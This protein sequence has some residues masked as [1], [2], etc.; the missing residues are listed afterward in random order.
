MV[1]HL[2]CSLVNAHMPRLYGYGLGLVVHPDLAAY[3]CA[4]T[5]DAGSQGQRMGGCGGKPRCSLERQWACAW[6]P[7]Q[8]EEALAAQ[9]VDNPAG[10]NE[11]IV[12]KGHWEA[13][14]PEIVQAVVCHDDCERAKEVHD[15][16]LAAYNRT[17]AQ[18]PLARIGG[19]GFT[20]LL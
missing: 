10:Y 13:R 18:T 19:G 11:F 20:E 8:L 7:S 15:A 9:L 14:L 5:R 6:A 17:R 12:A 16:F 4:Y 2:S 1:D 3:V